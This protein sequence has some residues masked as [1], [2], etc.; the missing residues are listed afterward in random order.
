MATKEPEPRVEGRREQERT[1]ELAK[2]ARM[3]LE[4]LLYYALVELKHA[5][6]PAAGA[7]GP[8]RI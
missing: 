3:S 1:M 4:E 5:R 2:L 6:T 7:Q 8:L